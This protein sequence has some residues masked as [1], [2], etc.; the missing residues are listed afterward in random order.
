MLSHCGQ[1]PQN[2]R[3]TTRYTASQSAAT[4]LGSTQI[5]RMKN[6]LDF[7]VFFPLPYRN[8]FPSG[9]RFYLPAP[10][11]NQTFT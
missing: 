10:F 3:A 5:M 7:S 11:S 8:L 1:P 9:E 6:D 2:E 4:Y